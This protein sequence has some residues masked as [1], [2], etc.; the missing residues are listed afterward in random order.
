M[1]DIILIQETNCLDR[2]EIKKA[3]IRRQVPIQEE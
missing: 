2:A 1:I 3:E